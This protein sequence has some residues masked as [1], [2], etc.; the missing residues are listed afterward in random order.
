MKKKILSLLLVMTTLLSGCG[1]KVTDPKF[2]GM[3]VNEI[4]AQYNSIES[5]YN[6]LAAEYN[7]LSKTY[8]SFTMDG[9]DLAIGSVG[10]GSGNLTFNSVDSKIIFPETFKYPNSE[11]VSASGKINIINNLSIVPSQNWI[12]KLVGSNLELEHTSGIS[13]IV[14][15][16]K[17]SQQFDNTQLKTEVLEPWLAS[18]PKELIDYKDVFVNGIGSGAQAT[19][20]TMIDSED[21]FLRCGMFSYSNY[22]VTY[23]F[24]YRSEQDANK[25]E[26]IVNLLNTIEIEGN[27]VTVE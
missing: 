19:T 20:P 22:T 2:A 23:V 18:L 24:V 13:G 9:A 10:D 12:C 7:T 14:K 4:I 26:S 11:A 21:S 17:I 25:D 3:S 27:K 15:V 1:E 8:E 16:G 5:M 6:D